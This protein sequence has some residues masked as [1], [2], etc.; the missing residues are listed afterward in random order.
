FGLA[1]GHGSEAREESPWIIFNFR[2]DR[3]WG[4]SVASERR[5]LARLGEHL[6]RLWPRARLEIHGF[7]TLPQP[8]HN[9]LDRTRRADGNAADG[10][11]YNARWTEELRTADLALGAYGSGMLRPT[12]VCPAVIALVPLDKQPYAFQECLFHDAQS[13]NLRAQFWRLRFLYGNSTLSDIAP[14]QVAHL[15]NTLLTMERCFQLFQGAAFA[16]PEPTPEQQ[17]RIAKIFSQEVAADTRRWHANAA[18]LDRLSL[19][20]RLWQ[21]LRRQ[22]SER[23]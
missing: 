1:V 12:A 23:D 8:V 16:D 11:D 4:G 15:V 7:A 17:A 20:S 3:C 22:A 6:R 14:R 5:R 10:Q 19:A 18:A 13:A 21:W 2:G 9:W